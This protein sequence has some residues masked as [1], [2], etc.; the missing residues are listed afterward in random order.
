MLD[1]RI[2]TFLTLCKERN[3]S[4]TAQIL[5][6]TQPAVTQHIQYLER[7]YN[8]KLFEYENKQLHLTKEGKI[9][10]Q[11]AL[12]LSASNNRVKEI[13]RGCQD[14]NIHLK[15]GCTLIISECVLPQIIKELLSTCPNLQI[16]MTVDTNERL[17]EGLSSGLYDCL[18]VEGCYNKESYEHHLFSKEDYIAISGKKFPPNTEIKDLLTETVICREEGS[19]PRNI[20]NEVLLNYRLS[21][22]DFPNYVESNNLTVIKELVKQKVGIAF[23]YKAAVLNEL[24]NQ[25]LYE[26]P[27]NLHLQKEFNF[28]VLKNSMFA[29]KFIDLYNFSKQVYEK[30]KQG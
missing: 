20:L 12:G 3:Y 30:N 21:I 19:I 10:E 23:V 29:Q 27:L 6:I 9:L 22:S 14:T 8:T 25:S 5:S 26:I 2:E 16:T 18:Y 7:Q 11:M 4:R 24:Q 13:I 17:F 15:I 28:V 1:Y